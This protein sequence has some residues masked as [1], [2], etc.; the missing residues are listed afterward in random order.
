MG[1]DIHITTEMLN[2]HDNKFYSFIGYG[3]DKFLSYNDCP[4]YRN[5]ELFGV[6]A[7]VRR[8]GEDMISEPRG[9]PK[10]ASTG[11]KEAAEAYGE[12]GHSHSY[13]LLSELFLHFDKIK[14]VSREFS[15][16]MTWLMSLGIP[17]DQIR[18]CFF[19]DN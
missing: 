13:F 9:I 7:G 4:R 1:C 6:L 12:D 8:G 19:F 10:N 5:Y 14:S 3:D 18:I 16:Y 11:Y 2:E 17:F 15:N